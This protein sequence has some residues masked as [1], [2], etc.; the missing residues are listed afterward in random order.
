M[1]RGLRTK[2]KRSIYE[3][4]MQVEVEVKTAVEAQ[5]LSKLLPYSCSYSDWEEGEGGG[6]DHAKLEQAHSETAGCR[7]SW[8]C[9]NKQELIQRARHVGHRQGTVYLDTC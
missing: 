3:V 4:D 6:A 2:Q 7:N 9:R 5:R 8:S 1:C